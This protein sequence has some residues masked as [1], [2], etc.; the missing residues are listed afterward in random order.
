M[1]TKF[2]NIHI[3]TK[4]LDEVIEVIEKSGCC[5]SYFVGSFEGWISVFGQCFSWEDVA[6]VAQGFS[7][8]LQYPVLSIGY[9]D[10]DIVDIGLFQNNS[11]ITQQV[12]AFDAEDY[13]L[14]HKEMEINSFKKVINLPIDIDKLA[15]VLKNEDV[16]EI[17]EGMQEILNIP[18]WMKYDWIEDDSEFKT[19]FILV[20][21]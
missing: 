6:T 20:K 15:I 17:I 5:S 10:D 13:G 16:S 7:K 4:N 21:S 12:V 2:S 18:L 14:E 19:H 3:Q 8:S 1:G 9:F 11:L